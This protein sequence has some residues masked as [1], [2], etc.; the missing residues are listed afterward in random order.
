MTKKILI[1]VLILILFSVACN[2]SSFQS[3]KEPPNNTES[4]STQIVA[5]DLPQPTI[6]VIIPTKEPTVNQEPTEEPTNEPTEISPTVEPT[7]ACPE[8]GIEE[9][10]SATPCW[11][12]TLAEMKSITALTN[13]PN[14]FAGINDGKLEFKHVVADEIYLYAFNTM[15]QYDEVILEASFTKIDPSSNQNG[16]TLVCHVNESGWYE[17]RIESGG[18]FGI[19]QYDAS[20]K[21]K[22]EN[23][24]QLLGQGGASALKVGANIENTIR[25]A[26]G[27]N[28]LTLI[29][30]GKEIWSEEFKDMINGGG[31]GLG[32]VSYSGKFPLHIAFERVE[33][34]KP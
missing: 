4:L 16:A 11:P 34:M 8:Y 2:L 7:E 14:E 20:K 22:G 19:F 25:W 3:N 5:T 29:I 9:F 26:C 13:S 23:P 32:L 6:A 21:S 24:Y 30:N 33:I 15:N 10:D 27:E 17:A 12:S 28:V 1:P 31:V 18:T